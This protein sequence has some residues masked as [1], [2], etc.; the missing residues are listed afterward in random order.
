MSRGENKCQGRT[1]C[2]FEYVK[3]Y[4]D[5]VVEV[6]I[7]CGKKLI[8]NK[9]EGKIDQQRN[10]RNHIRDTVQPFGTTAPL[11]RELYG[12]KAMDKFKIKEKETRDPKSE[13][14]EDLRIMERLSNRGYTDKEIL[15]SR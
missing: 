9:V 6:C 7:E 1:L 15:A 10:I 14:R 12:D 4:P 3:D 11:F 5:A 2:K 8:Y 13:A